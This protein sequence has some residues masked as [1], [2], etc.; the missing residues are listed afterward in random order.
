MTANCSNCP[1]KPY[2]YNTSTTFK[3]SDHVMNQI[4]LGTEDNSV[5]LSGFVA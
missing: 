2:N 1:A 4:V 5:T 3:K